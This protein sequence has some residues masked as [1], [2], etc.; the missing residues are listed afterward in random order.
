MSDDVARRIDDARRRPAEVPIAPAAP[1]TGTA[2]AEEDSPE[3]G[4]DDRIEFSRDDDGRLVA[5]LS[6]S[7]FK[8]LAG[9]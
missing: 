4:D 7:R 5:R 1:I 8:L 2:A 3:V 6:G 9:N